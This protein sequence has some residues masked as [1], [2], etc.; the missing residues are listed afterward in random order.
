VEP[1]LIGRFNSL[2]PNGYNLSNGGE[3][4]FGY[5]HKPDSIERSASKHR[6][7]PCHPNTRAAAVRTHKGVPKSP[8]HRAKIAAGHTG[9]SKSEVTKAKIRA[10]WANRRA[11]GEFKTLE[12][13]SHA[14]K[15]KSRK[16]ASAAIA[17]IPFEL[18]Q[19]VAKV[20]K[21]KLTCL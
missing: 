7:I 12:P 20:Y 13:Y 14:S 15:S 4:P 16:A 17:K 5:K 3:G 19:W 21:P 1:V 9:K 10:Y 8:E 2:A 18:A 11:N 6:G